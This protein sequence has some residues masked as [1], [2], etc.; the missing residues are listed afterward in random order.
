MFRNFK[1]KPIEVSAVEVTPEYIR[2]LDPEAGPILPRFDTRTGQPEGVEWDSLN[3]AGIGDFIV[4]DGDRSPGLGIIP[5]HEF[6]AR[7]DPAW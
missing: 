3:Y 5:G 7:Y 2:S 6:K 4:D 1:H